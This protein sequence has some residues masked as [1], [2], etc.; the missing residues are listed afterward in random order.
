MKK[1]KTKR[2][3]TLDTV[4]GKKNKKQTKK[5]V[6]HPVLKTCNILQYIKTVVELGNEAFSVLRKFFQSSLQSILRK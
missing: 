1:S 4:L 5:Q 6:K 3:N 2:N